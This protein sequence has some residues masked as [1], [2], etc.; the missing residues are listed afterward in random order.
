MTAWN[1]VFFMFVVYTLSNVIF[2]LDQTG[3]RKARKIRST[4]SSLEPTDDTITTA[5]AQVYIWLK[6]KQN[7]F[8][9]FF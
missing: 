9:W 5:Q 7:K 1:N 4:D 3:A 2:T 6:Q 8:I